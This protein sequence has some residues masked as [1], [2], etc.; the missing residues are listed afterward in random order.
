MLVPIGPVG[1]FSP[2]NFP[3]A[4]GVLGGDTASALAAGCPVVVKGHPS[5]PRTSAAMCAR[6]FADAVAAT[7]AP[8]DI[9]RLLQSGDPAVSRALV[10]APEIAAVGFTGSQAVGRLAVR[11]GRGPTRADP[12]LRRARQHQ[13]AVYRRG[14][15][16]GPRRRH[17]RRLHRRR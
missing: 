3:L 4:Y 10:S 11:P 6:A 8:A 15:G 2:S 17:R 7:G 13:S 12:V 16:S 9:L 5:H 14:R 1:V